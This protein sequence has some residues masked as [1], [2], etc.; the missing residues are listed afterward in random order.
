[1]AATKITQPTMDELE[2][3][4]N[5]LKRILSVGDL[6]TEKECME[7]RLEIFG[8]STLLASVSNSAKWAFFIVRIINGMKTQTPCFVSMCT[9]SSR[10]AKIP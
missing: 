6:H 5:W 7:N 8:C 4:F 2:R 1:M 9:G 10:R 3:L